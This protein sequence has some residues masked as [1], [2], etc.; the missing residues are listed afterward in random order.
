M[1]S[2]PKKYL[3]DSNRQNMWKNIKP[4]ISKIDKKLNFKNVYVVGSFVS[5]KKNP[6]D[7]DFAVI[8]KVKD[9]K[10]NL[11]YPV[12]FIILPENEDLDQYLKFFRKYMAKKYGSSCKP[13]KLK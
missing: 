4:I 8:A 11:A 5:K 10:S 13:I 7:I 3:S 2:L 6:N 12:D 1:K 9:K